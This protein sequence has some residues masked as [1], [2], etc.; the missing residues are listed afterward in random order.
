MKD[1]WHTHQERLEKIRVA[2]IKRGRAKLEIHLFY[3]KINSLKWNPDRLYWNNDKQT[4]FMNYSTD[5]GRSLLKKKNTPL[6]L[7]MNKWANALPPTFE[8]NLG[9]IWA[10]DWAM[11]EANLIWLSWHKGLAVNEWRGVTSTTID[12]KYL[13]CIED[14]TESIVN[15][16]W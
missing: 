6:A 13:M 9:N 8:F 7:A 2:T 14:N 10:S 16:F 1:D 5:L 11:K 3:G 12:T 15:R 4:F